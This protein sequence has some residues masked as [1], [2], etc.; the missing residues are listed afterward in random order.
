MKEEEQLLKRLADLDYLAQKRHMV[1]FSDFLNSNEYSSYL[2]VKRDFLCDTRSY[3][4]IACLERQ[5]IAFIPDAL[6]FNE[7]YPI[8]CFQ[9]CPKSKKFAQSFNHR[10]VLGALMSLGIERKLI[11]DI[12]FKSDTGYFLAHRRIR[13]FLMEEFRQIKHTDIEL[14]IVDNLPE[15]FAPNFEYYRTTLASTRLDCVVA[16]LARCSRSNSAGIISQGMVFVNSKE[17]LHNTYLCKQ[18]DVISIR[19]TGKF[20]VVELGGLTKKGKLIMEYGKYS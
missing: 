13:E 19:G 16:E 2:A 14:L 8:D 3:N 5:M 10:D 11:G 12:I 6:I 15:K 17:E 9:I 20:K 4:Q 18:E 1:C 7:E